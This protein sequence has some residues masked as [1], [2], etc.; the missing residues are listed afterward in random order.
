VLTKGAFKRGQENPAWPEVANE[1]MGQSITFLPK[2]KTEILG[3]DV[4]CQAGDIL[5]VMP[6][7]TFYGGN[8][9][10]SSLATPSLYSVT[11]SSRAGVEFDMS[12]IPLALRPRFNHIFANTSSGE[13]M[14]TS[15]VEIQCCGVITEDV[16]AT[17]ICSAC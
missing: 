13:R 7:A 17:S 14:C 5:L 8:T 12:A 15:C 6:N 3:Y 2:A 4:S 9:Y 11:N 1:T 10:G 16:Q